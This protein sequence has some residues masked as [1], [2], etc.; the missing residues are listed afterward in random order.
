MVKWLHISDIHLNRR[1]METRRMRTN[2]I[3]FLKE[4]EITCKYLFITGDLRYAPDGGFDS[5]TVSFLHELRRTLGVSIE[6]VFIIHGNHDINRDAPEREKALQTI[7]KDMDKYYVPKIGIIRESELEGIYQSQNDF[8]SVMSNF[9]E[10]MPERIQKY[11]ESMQP[12]FVV[13]AD[14]FNILHVNSTLVY[15]AEHEKDLIIGTDKLMDA[16]EDIDPNKPSI[17]LTHYS[18]DFLS[19]PEQNEV[20]RL[21]VDYN[22]HIWL[23]GHEHD[24]MLR[25]QRDYFYEFQSG[26]LLYEGSDSKSCF[27]V[28]EFE[29][30]D[31]SGTISG[32]EWDHEDGWRRMSRISRQKDRSL[33]RFALQGADTIRTTLEI[34]TSSAEY[35]SQIEQPCAFE[36]YNPENE[37]IPGMSAEASK[38]VKQTMGSS[39]RKSEPCEDEAQGASFK[40]TV[41]PWNQSQ[42]ISILMGEGRQ[43]T[44]K[45]YIYLDSDI[46]PFMDAEV[47]HHHYDFFD[48]YIFHNDTM[49]ITVT[50]IGELLTY[51]SVGYNLSRYTD[52]DERLLHF[53]KIKKYMDSRRVFIKMTGHEENNLSFETQLPTV[54]WKENV[55]RTDYWIDQMQRISKIEQHFRVKF[56][57]PVK[58][59]EDDYLAIAVLSDSVEEKSCR[60]LPVIPIKNWGLRKSFKLE[61]K[62]YLGNADRLLRLMLFGYTFK[63]VRQY[64]LPGKYVWN[65]KKMGLE[66]EGHIGVPVGVDFE[67]SYEEEMNWNLISFAPFEEYKDEFD[68]DAI[69]ELDGEMESFFEKYVRLTHNIQKNRQLYLNYNDALNA[70]FGESQFTKDSYEAIDKKVKNKITVNRMT[71]NVVSVGRK[72]VAEIDKTMAEFFE[73]ENFSVK[74]SNNNLGYIWMVVMNEYS[75]NGHFPISVKVGGEAYYDLKGIRSEAEAEQDSTLVELTK[76]YE[77]CAE[78]A[79]QGIL[80]YYDMIR[81]YSYTL[82]EIQKNYY[83]RIESV[84]REYTDTMNAIIEKNPMLIHNGEKFKN[85]V[86]YCLASDQ[87]NLHI[88]MRDADMCGDFYRYKSEADKHFDIQSLGMNKVIYI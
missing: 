81:N 52:V 9:Y 83:E 78:F 79:T 87:N 13:A 17:L 41:L 69:P 20:L 67:I 3:P 34:S 71:D 49:E 62:V 88:F 47:L 25:M 14:D 60:I 66:A 32:Y 48:R 82:A 23:A 27:L 51:I 64:L 43:D 33:Y 54:E 56:Y 37:I 84:V 30:G 73:D 77:E 36:K 45:G 80:P 16:L 46:A 40:I 26:N 11:N 19:R 4:E 63:P 72:L 24:D 55:A 6:N 74:Y 86:A 21:L 22:V 38:M 2:L 50:K 35:I 58:A 12:H 8:V 85:A 70:I 1:G 76:M 57:L 10:G 59:S 53:R 7:W 61:E 28:G 29:P 39:L 42:G 44:Y 75:A 65:R 68:I 18:Y 31:Y 15:S 5:D